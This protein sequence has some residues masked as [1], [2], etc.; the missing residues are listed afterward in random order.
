VYTS[1]QVSIDGS[2]LIPAFILALSLLVHKHD[3]LLH[4]RLEQERNEDPHPT[5]HYFPK[6]QNIRYFDNVVDHCPK[7]KIDPF[8]FP[9]INPDIEGAH[10]G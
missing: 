6:R 8:P 1:I 7:I 4:L 2:G 9:R 3:I 10:S 5:F